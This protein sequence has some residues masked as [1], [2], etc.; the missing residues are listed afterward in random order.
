MPV[1]A[2]VRIDHPACKRRHRNALSPPPPP[3]PV[4]LRR[5]HFA[6]G[7]GHAGSVTACP[8]ARWWPHIPFTAGL[9]AAAAID[10]DIAGVGWHW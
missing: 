5:S 10:Y 2:S 1:P 9:S 4:R 8:V 7:R 3:E 6:I